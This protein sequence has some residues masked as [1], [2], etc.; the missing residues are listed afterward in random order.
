M[1]ISVGAAGQMIL[2]DVRRTMDLR[3][4]VIGFIDDDSNKRSRFILNCV[5]FTISFE[6]DEF[7]GQLEE[8]TA[9]SSGNMKKGSAGWLRRSSRHICL[10]FYSP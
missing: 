4:R 1:I 7:L 9:A 5:G 6:T 10:R 2:R 3:D 8:L